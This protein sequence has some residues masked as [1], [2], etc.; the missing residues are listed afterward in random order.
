MLIKTP[1]I[2]IQ[3]VP[4]KIRVKEI[5]EQEKIAIERF[6]PLFPQGLKTRRI[7]ILRSS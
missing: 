4:E 3:H 1:T 5:I 2:Q 7:Q 6:P